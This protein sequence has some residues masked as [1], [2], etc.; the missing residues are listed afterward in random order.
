MLRSVS[1]PSLTIWPV[2]LGP[3]WVTVRL[4]KVTPLAGA[5]VMV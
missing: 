4:A 5:E 3:V 1:V 2:T